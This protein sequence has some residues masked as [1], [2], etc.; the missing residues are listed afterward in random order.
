MRKLVF[1]KDP[2]RN[3]KFQLPMKTCRFGNVEIQ[4]GQ[5]HD[6]AY[7]IIQEDGSLVA[8]QV[9]RTENMTQEQIEAAVPLIVET[10]IKN[11]DIR[12]YQKRRLMRVLEIT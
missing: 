10:R 6:R 8:S 4:L 12:T 9:L 5:Y 7:I 3:E 1:T 11:S 2:T